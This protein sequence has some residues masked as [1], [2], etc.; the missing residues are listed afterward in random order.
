MENQKL[1]TLLN[2]ALETTNEEREKSDDLNAGY[3]EQEK[4]WELIV[5]YSGSLA[6][7]EDMGIEPEIL[8]GGYAILKVPQHLIDPISRLAQIE[9]IEKPKRLF[10][11]LYQARAA[12]C[13]LPVQDAGLGL[14]GEGVLVAVLD[15][16]IDYF[17]PDFRKSDGRTRILYL[18]DQTLGQVFDQDAIN[19][20]LEALD[21]QSALAV[22]PSV[23][24]SGHGTAVAGIAAGNGRESGGRYRGVAYASPLLIVKLGPSDR[25]GFP[26]TTQLM[27]AVD[28]AVRK[29][30]ELSMPL[31]V[32][33]S[34]GNTYGSHDGTSLLET[35]L[36]AAAME[37]RNVIVAGTGNE[38]AAGGHVSGKLQIGETKEILLSVAPY[39]TGFGLQLWKSYGDRFQVSLESPSG[40]RLGPFRPEPGARRFWYE[41]T[42]ILVYYG[43]PS[44]YS[45]AQE[46][47]MDFIPEENYVNGGIWRIFL[48]PE[49]LASGQYDL[50]LPSYGILNTS[51]R[52]LQSTPE[53]TLTIP[54]TADRVISVAAYDAFY[55]S[56]ADFSGRGNVYGGRFAKPDL[57]APGVDISTTA[58]GGGYESVTGTSFA[59]PFVTGTS[60]LLMQWGIKLGNDPY[61]YG[62]KVKASLIRGAR[63]LSGFAE[64]PNSQL[65]LW[66]TLRGGQHFVK[67][68]VQNIRFSIIS[69][70][71]CM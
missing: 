1:E 7:V 59:A 10:F 18:W 35:F 25:D 5:R 34:F 61:L 38:G 55:E 53:V 22:V 71:K 12:S 58:S 60:A 65:G 37:G 47:Y 62:E 66:S 24:A 46:I 29:A 20:A 67:K 57:A 41:N 8:L 16:G 26:G 70:A 15:S 17:H 44:P 27:R 13:L 69:T 31:A 40:I 14:D 11:A 64:W 43:E 28:F 36:N 9:Y 51:T 19:A 50:W 49:R 23:D 32:N 6:E 63:H 39:E 68:S 4:T 3:N 2:L 30:Q 45:L 54:S 42:K 21:R 52:F 33:I 48:E 56:Y